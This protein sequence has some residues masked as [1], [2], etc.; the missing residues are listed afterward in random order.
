[1]VGQNSY[2]QLFANNR[3]WVRASLEADASYF[4]R[5]AVGQSPRFLFIG[6]SDSRVNANEITGTQAGEMF[7]HRNIANVVIATDMNVMSVVQYA[8]EVLQV[9]HVIVCGHYGCGGVRAA[10]DGVRHGLIDKWL[11]SIRDVY[12]LH[13]DD[14]EAVP[15]PEERHRRL[16]EWN[17]R[18]QVYRLCATSFVQRAWPDDRASHVHGWVYD[19]KEGLLRDLE[20]DP[21]A[22]PDAQFDLY[23]SSDP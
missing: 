13:R 17:V 20:V 8:I 19:L 1:M 6:C 21:D 7:I 18:E 12:R 14:I 16:V 4:E 2:E 15:D 11:R 9:E 10:V 5:L 23:R 3:E 22:D